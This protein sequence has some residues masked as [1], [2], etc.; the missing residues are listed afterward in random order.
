MPY[1]VLQPLG[2]LIIGNECIVGAVNILF[3]FN[4]G[5]ISLAISLSFFFS[6]FLLVLGIPE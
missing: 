4:N 2:S 5:F 3:A 6:S 1:Y